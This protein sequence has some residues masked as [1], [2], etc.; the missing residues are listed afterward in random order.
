MTMSTSPPSPATLHDNKSL[1][2]TWLSKRR[3]IFLCLVTTAVIWCVLLMPP[4]PDSQFVGEWQVENLTGSNAPPIVRLLADGSALVL[5]NTATV[6]T[7]DCRWGVR[8]GVLFLHSSSHTNSFSFEARLRRLF[9]R[10]MRSPLA[11]FQA[12]DL[13]SSFAIESRSEDVMHLRSLPG[14]QLLDGSF[15]M[16]RRPAKNDP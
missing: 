13:D 14:A 10:L 16:R 9:Q 8:R 5:N 6:I 11:S 12:P 3:L 1:K 7:L 15:A 2:R 4:R